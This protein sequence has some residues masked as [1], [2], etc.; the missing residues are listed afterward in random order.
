MI[1]RGFLATAGATLVGACG[2][3]T[4]QTVATRWPPIGNIV[5]VDGLDVHYWEQGAGQPVVLIQ[6]ASGNLR[7]FTFALAPL[8]ANNFRVIAFDR[9]GFGYS[10]RLP[11]MGWEPRAQA[12]HLAKATSALGA[13]RPIVLGHSWGGALA[14]AWAVEDGTNLKGVVSLAGATMPWGGDLAFHNTLLASQFTGPPLAWLVSR[15][16][17]EKLIASFLDSTFA[18]QSVPEGYADY[19]GGPLATRSATVQGNAQDLT[20]LNTALEHQSQSYAEVTCPVEILHG[21]A[22]D[23][24][25]A[26]LHA[27]GLHALLPNSHLTLLEDVGHMPHHARPEAI[28]IALSRLAGN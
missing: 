25:I 21:T 7:D 4:S 18:P 17:S 14:M 1:R 12:R 23:T 6:G 3:P 24:V 19:V 28:Q 27:D 20:Q 9:P 10:A 2:G 5:R 15:N 22:D 13:V 26:G 11:E 8:L 16:F